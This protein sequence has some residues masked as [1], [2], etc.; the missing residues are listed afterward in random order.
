MRLEGT[1]ELLLKRL[2]PLQHRHRPLTPDV[3]SHSTGVY[4]PCVVSYNYSRE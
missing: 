2:W 1:S 4:I 3:S